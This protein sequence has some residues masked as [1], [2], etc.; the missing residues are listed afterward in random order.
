MKKKIVYFLLSMLTVL[1]M[2]INKKMLYD[3]VRLNI[4][5]VK[6]SVSL[7]TIL[8]VAFYLFYKK[9][10]KKHYIPIVLPLSILTTT[11]GIP[12]IAYLLGD[13]DVYVSSINTIF[14][15]MNRTVLYSL[16]ISTLLPFI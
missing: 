13:T 5:I 14:G 16:S 6:L 2:S 11:I 4:N 1:A 3:K 8:V 10:N 9:Y 12:A 7:M 15:S